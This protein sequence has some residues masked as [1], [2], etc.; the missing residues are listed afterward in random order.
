MQTSG[1]VDQL[2]DVHRN[3]PGLRDAACNRAGLRGLGDLRRLAQTGVDFAKTSLDGFVDHRPVHTASFFAGRVTLAGS[4][5][6]RSMAHPLL[7]HHTRS[8]A[9]ESRAD[10]E[11]CYGVV[12][13]RSSIL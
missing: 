8:A 11:Q 5:E 3:R 10:P 6:A 7:G 1:L 2:F 13:S 4:I 12:R 9:W